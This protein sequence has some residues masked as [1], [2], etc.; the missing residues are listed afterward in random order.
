MALNLFEDVV[1][2]KVI[3]I[4]DKDTLLTLLKILDKI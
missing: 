2:E 3:E 1:D 4:L